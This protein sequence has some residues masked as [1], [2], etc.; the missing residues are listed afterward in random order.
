MKLV[1]TNHGVLLVTLNVLNV[2][3]NM[4][5]E[6]KKVDFY[7]LSKIGSTRVTN[8]ILLLY[9]LHFIKSILLVKVNW[10]INFN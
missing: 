9:I 10:R 2:F 8:Y 5:H 3:K 1:C 7:Y 4:T 6:T